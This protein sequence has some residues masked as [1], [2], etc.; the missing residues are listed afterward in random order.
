MRII[1]ILNHVQEIGNGIVNVAVDLACLQAKSGY[2]V[3]VI[4]AGGEYEKLL[5]NCGVKHYQLDQTR[6]PNSII[7]AAVRYRAIAAEFQPDIVH[8]HMMT[9][10]ILARIF[11]GNKY[12]LVSTVH[13]EFQRS[14]LLMGLADRV[15]AVR[16]GGARF[17]GKTRYP[18][19]QVAGSMQWNFWQPP[20]PANTRLSTFRVTTSSDRYCSGNVSTQKVSQ[21]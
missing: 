19:K 10:V 7:K 18:R 8:A 16:Q 21:S 17:Y 12:T 2:E 13:N 4:S 3:A 5:N 1:H 6:K 11:Q 20:H 14:S 9:G 15:I